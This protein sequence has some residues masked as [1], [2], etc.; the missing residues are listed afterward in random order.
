MFV[1]LDKNGNRIYADD[2]QRHVECFCP[3]C[4]E[5]LTHKRGKHNRAHFA[6]KQKSNCF[7]NLNKD[8]M[9]EWHI[10]MQS[11]F[12]KEKREYRFHDND[13]GETHIADVFDEETNTVI[14]FQHSQINEDEYLSRTNFHLK[15]GRRI[16]WIF[17][18][19]SDQLKEGYLGKFKK[20]Y[21]S[22]PDYKYEETPLESGYIIGVE[23]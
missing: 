7:M 15:N 10:R 1:A 17:D 18:E 13:T 16:V 22:T 11:F 3:V 9:G 8:Y 5:T 6:H 14:E 19:S 2:E 21:F 20:D 4:G 23:R 12:P